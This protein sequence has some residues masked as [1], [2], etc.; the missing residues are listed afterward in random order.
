MTAVHP[1]T[2]FLTET[3][4]NF[5]QVK[6]GK[7]VSNAQLVGKRLAEHLGKMIQK[8]GCLRTKDTAGNVRTFAAAEVINLIKQQVS[9]VLGEKSEL[10]N[11]TIDSE[12]S[13]AFVDHAKNKL[14]EQLTKNPELLDKVQQSLKNIN[15][16]EGKEP[17]NANAQMQIF[18]AMS[19]EVLAS[20]KADYTV[21]DLVKA[22]T[23]K[24]DTEGAIRGLNKQGLTQI[25]NEMNMAGT[26]LNAKTAAKT[27]LEPDDLV[28]DYTEPG[29]DEEEMLKAFADGSQTLSNEELEP[30]HKALITYIS[31]VSKTKN[32]AAAKAQLQIDL[33]G[34]KDRQKAFAKYAVGVGKKLNEG[35]DLD[36]VFNQLGNFLPGLLGSGIMG[37]IFSSLLGISGAWGVVGSLVMTAL[38]ATDDTKTK[39]KPPEFIGQQAA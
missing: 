17:I 9:D 21:G 35:I 39:S 2:S 29:S 15:L 30:V 26:L 19:R 18:N 23:Q 22:L 11:K 27:G 6:D 13:Q 34:L 12:L 5:V 33:D 16:P 1:L 25:S 3:V 8:D 7:L 24:I 37:Y 38:A 10:V 31:T 20:M 14:L 36:Q 4:T 28:L 32:I